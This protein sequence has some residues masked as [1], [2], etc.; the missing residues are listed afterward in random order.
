MA[1]HALL[2]AFIV[3]VCALIGWVTNVVAIKMVFRPLERVR[4]LG[5][6][7]WQGVVPRHA[8]RFAGEVA[9]MITEDF[10][11][12]RDL[13][14]QVDPDV[15]RTRLDPMLSVVVDRALDRVVGRLPEEVR[16][17]GLFGPAVVASVKRQ[18]LAEMDRLLPELRSLLV[19]RIDEII[20]FRAE[21][22][23]NLTG[24]NVDRLERFILTIAG[25]EFRWIEYYGGILGAGFGVLYLGLVAPGW[26]S[27]WTIPAIGVV[28]GLATN[29][30]AIQMIFVPRR[31]VRLGPLTFEGALPRRQ[32][33]IAAVMAEVVQTEMP[34]FGEILDM[35]LERGFGSEVRKLVSERL[36]AFLHARLEIALKLLA[37][38]G[39]E[40]SL[41]GAVEDVLEHLAA[42]MG[43]IVERGKAE[44]EAQIDVAAVVRLSLDDMDR[45]RFEQT[46]RGLLQHDEGILI[47][48]GGLLGGVVGLAQLGVVTVLG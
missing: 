27:L 14:L 45:L 28:V 38:T 2:F 43:A 23:G 44:A 47:A 4:I 10:F 15:I 19:R 3:V 33:E 46:L 20:D 11:M 18:L 39:S 32:K 26:V 37:A 12:L 48:Y 36:E 5:P 34:R 29:W 25:K 30:I 24:G 8:P 13:A 6:I 21:I 22:I 17:R 31:P 1:E 42:E 41:A 35:M 9:D 16:T 7:G 40:I